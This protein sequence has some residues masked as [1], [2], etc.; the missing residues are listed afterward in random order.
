[1]DLLCWLFSWCCL[2]SQLFLFLVSRTRDGTLDIPHADFDANFKPRHK[3]HETKRIHPSS[4]EEDIEMKNRTVNGTFKSQEM[5]QKAPARQAPVF[6]NTA[7]PPRTLPA[8]TPRPRSD[9]VDSESSTSSYE[10]PP[11][12][13]LPPVRT[14]VPNALGGPRQRPVARQFPTPQLPNV[15]A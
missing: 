7:L 3:R 4:P 2:V 8:F 10:G 5:V 6:N 11:A 9:S 13:A 12:R 1:M 15:H 14:A